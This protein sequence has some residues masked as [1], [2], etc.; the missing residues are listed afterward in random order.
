LRSVIDAIEVQQQKCVLV[1]G[2]RPFNSTRLAPHGHAGSGSFN[3]TLSVDQPWVSANETHG[4]AGAQVTLTLDPTGL[5]LGTHQATATISADAGV[6]DSPYQ[7]LLRLILVPV[8]H[9]V[10]L[11]V[12]V[13]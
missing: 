7:V 9:D 6:Y 10:F 11:P 1:C 3:W 8:R 13:L 12:I 4:V 2:V 5:A